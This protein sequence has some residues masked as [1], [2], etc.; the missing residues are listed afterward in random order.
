LSSFFGIA[1]DH[2][3][4]RFTFRLSRN[5]FTIT[6]IAAKKCHAFFSFFGDTDLL[7]WISH[8]LDTGLTEN[9]VFTGELYFAVKAIAAFALVDYN[10]F[11]GKWSLHFV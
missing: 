7:L 5:R 8:S 1:E 3:R 11:T 2:S 10:T 6:K 4:E 9:P